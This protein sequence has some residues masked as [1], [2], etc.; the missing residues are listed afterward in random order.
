MEE[1]R[2][3]KQILNDLTR[4]DVDS[5]YRQVGIIDVMGNIAMHTGSKCIEK[6]GHRVGKNY[7]C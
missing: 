5:Q 3:P 6:V 1:G 2:L 7:S 4:Q